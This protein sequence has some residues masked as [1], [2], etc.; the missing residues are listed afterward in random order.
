MATLSY[1]SANNISAS[2]NSS[3]SFYNNTPTT[4]TNNNHLITDITTTILNNNEDLNKLLLPFSLEITEKIISYAYY[5]DS[6]HVVYDYEINNDDSDLKIAVS[7]SAKNITKSNNRYSNLSNLMLVNS[8]F[9]HLCI[10]FQ[11]KY[12][13]FI[14]SFSF[15]KFLVNLI[16]NNEIGNYVEFLDFQEF[17]AIGLGK[18]KESIF[19]IPNLTNTTLLKCLKLI[20]KNLHTLLLNESI[21]TDINFE[22]LNFI[23]NDLKNLKNLDFCGCSNVELINYFDKLIIKN[24]IKIEKLSFHE[25]L[26]LPTFIYNK[27]LP[28]LPNLKRLD[29]SHTQI[30]LNSLN[31][32]LNKNVK[33]TH[34]SLRKCSQLGT[35]NEFI[36]FLKNPSICGSIEDNNL[37]ENLRWLNIQQCFSSDILTTERLDLIIDIIINSGI[38][39]RYLNLNGFANLNGDHIIK[40]CENL[41]NLESLSICDI[42]LNLSDLNDLNFLNQIN[43]LKNLK[44]LDVSSI[45]RNFDNLKDL[46][47]TIENVKVFEIKPF[48]SDNLAH[49]LILNRNRNNNINNNENNS[50][51]N[52]REEFW[53]VYNNK[54]TSRR[55]WIHKVKSQ[56][57]SK[58]ID[59]YETD[60]AGVR[61]VEWDINTGG[62][63]LNKVKRVDWLGLACVKINC[64]ENVDYALQDDDFGNDF[65]VRGLYKYYSLNV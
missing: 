13:D 57:E 46:M 56:L 62:L 35:F 49:L 16:N 28:F 32:F 53:R 9:Y 63:I 26:N 22:I 34:L 43:L 41:I 60:E 19:K 10:Q 61:L 54:G 30:T 6:P 17:T 27:I 1:N 31:S 14:R 11:Y 25:C 55:C 23:F 7:N 15:H 64:C 24:E 48:L 4:N 45:I 12:C 21:D 29:L 40:I 65:C 58:L 37:N 36:K 50:G 38:N 42:N 52:N 39:L 47:L 8:K 2:K 18:S 5:Q 20:S 44:F 59:N 33:L 3:S 51:N